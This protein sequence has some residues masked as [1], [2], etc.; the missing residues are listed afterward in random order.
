MANTTQLKGNVELADGTSTVLTIKKPLTI[1]YSP[2][3]VSG[4]IGFTGT[5]NFTGALVNGVNNVAPRISSTTLTGVY[6]ISTLFV[7]NG[8]TFTGVSLM[9]LETG[10]F[11]GSVIAQ[12]YIEGTLVTFL[13][14]RETVTGFYNS[15][16][17][18]EFYNAIQVTWSAP[19]PTTPIFTSYNTYTRIG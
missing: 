18:L 19:N 11:G 14:R 10:Y 3:F 2:T 5:S 6:A 13:D 7:I 1:G 12:S 4:Q 15:T 9:R 17:G 16:A 8:G